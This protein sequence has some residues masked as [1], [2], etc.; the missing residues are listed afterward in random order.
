MC[1]HVCNLYH[2]IY[3]RRKNTAF[4]GNGESFLWRMREPRNTTPR[5][6]SAIDLASLESDGEVFPWTGRDRL[7][8]HCTSDRIAVGGNSENDGGSGFGLVIEKN[9]LRGTSNFSTTF[10]SPPLSQIRKPGESF[11]IVN[12]EVWTLTPCMDVHEAEKM[13]FG[14]LFLEFNTAK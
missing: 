12:M 5:S 13:E 8:Q 3:N 9:L 14:R 4:F 2:I 7:I 11:E 6:L 10:N 1:I